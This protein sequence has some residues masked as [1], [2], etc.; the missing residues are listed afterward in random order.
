MTTL[1]ASQARQDKL[2]PKGAAKRAE[3]RAQ[4]AALQA[5]REAAGWSTSIE[6]LALDVAISVHLDG[7][8]SLKLTMRFLNERLAR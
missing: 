8:K 6:G 4:L 7:D 2:D 3:S 1:E 5:A